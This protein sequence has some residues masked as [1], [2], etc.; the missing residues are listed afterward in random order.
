MVLKKTRKS[1][2]CHDYISQKYQK[3][4][5]KNHWSTIICLL[6]FFT[7]H[8]KN[9]H[10]SRVIWLP[11]FFKKFTKIILLSWLFCSKESQL[12]QKN[13]KKVMRIGANTH[14]KNHDFVFFSKSPLEK[15]HFNCILLLKWGKF[16]RKNPF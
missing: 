5:R 1:H 9:D 3:M 8:E 11:I 10:E 7:F 13:I 16:S 14:Q 15:I 4:Y 12:C 6:F 2:H